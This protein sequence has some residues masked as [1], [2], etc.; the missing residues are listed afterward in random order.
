MASYESIINKAKKDWNCSELM[1]GASKSRG[2]KIPFSSP[3]LNYATYG[4]IPRRR[5]T[6]FYG[7]YGGGK[8]TSSVDI[9]KN[10]RKIFK[11]E[12]ENQLSD[13][14][15]KFANG[16]KQLAAEIEDLEERGPKKILYLDLEHSFDEAWAKT[17]GVDSKEIEIM[18][19]PDL[20][21][22][23]LLETLK[24][25]IESGE[26]GFVV[27]DSAPSLVT[28][29][30]LEKKFGER[31][32]A[33]SAGLLTIFCRKIVPILTR[34]DCTMIIINQIRDNMDNPYVVNMPGGNALKFY[35]SLMMQFRIGS[36][37][38]FLGN[39]LP[40]S[41]ENPAGYIIN[42]KLTKQK[43]A[44]FDRKNASYYL[45]AQSGIRIDMD[46]A[47][48]AVNKYQIIKKSSAWFTICD[49]ETKEPLIE[50]DKVV[51]VQGMARVLDYLQQHPEYFDKLQKYILA[52][53]EGNSRSDE[54]EDVN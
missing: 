23:D 31:T 38:D 43:S 18:Q 26:V 32:V 52:D 50:D 40:Q 11:E 21:A 20:A 10:A 30:E 44:P 6:I 16:N 1:E 12:Y 14:R 48:L 3:L 51:K 2:D 47:N 15:T 45:M 19:P 36:P 9:C 46:F 5:I 7:N 8:S 53:I 22:E 54:V 25:L 41:A 17:L 35:A 49:P 33:S 29:A 13:L 27:L 28:R 24:Q 37:V 39:E 34:Y 42:V 4:G